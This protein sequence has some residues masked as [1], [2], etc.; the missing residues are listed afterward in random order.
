MPYGAYTQQMLLT[1][2]AGATV[3]YDNPLGPLV[4]DEVTVVM[5]LGDADLEF[6]A[7]SEESFDVINPGATENVSTLLLVFRQSLGA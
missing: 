6:D 4:P 2:P 3:E 1:V 5:H 7:W